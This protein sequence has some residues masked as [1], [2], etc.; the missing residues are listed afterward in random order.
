M[1]QHRVILHVDLDYFFAQCEEREDPSL[2]NK[3]VVV[4]VYSGRTPDSGAV[5]TTNYIARGLGVKSGIP[6]AFAKRILKERDDAVFLPVNEE[7]YRRVSESI[8]SLLRTYADRF[9]QESIDEAFL[10][11]SKR[12]DGDFEKAEDI[13]LQLK[14]EINSKERI[15]CSVGVGPNKLVAKTASDFRKPDGLTIV[16]PEEVTN[17]LW[18]LEVGKLYG[19][20]KK[21]EKKMVEMG[22][23]T[24][25]DL[26]KFDAQKLT[27]VFGPNLGTYFHKSASGVDDESVEEREGREQISRIATLKE[28]TRDVVKIVS[29][30][31]RLAEEVHRESVEEGWKFRS[32]GVLSFM[33]DLTVHSRTRTLEFP[34]SKL[35]DIITTSM[36]L[37]KELLDGVPELQIRRIGVKVS[38]LSKP[39][40]QTSLEDFP[41]QS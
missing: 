7:L 12:V 11:V 32:V 21:T 30:L 17:F 20:G 5:S 38:N 23:L 10:D 15:T 24:I 36:G 19:V 14:R 26:A 34:S 2:R 16:S 31:K 29:D 37:L 18:P 33:E 25:G 28:N 41:G 4:C 3:P 40:G 8:M 13:A 39:E 35:D 22:I 9:E 1:Q 6:I 27:E